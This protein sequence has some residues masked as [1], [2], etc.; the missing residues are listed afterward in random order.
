[1]WVTKQ[2]CCRDGYKD[3]S[4]QRRQPSPCRGT[5]RVNGADRTAGAP[6]PMLWF[7][8]TVFSAVKRT[9]A[10][11]LHRE[12]PPVPTD[13][14]GRFLPRPDVPTWGRFPIPAHPPYAPSSSPSSLPQSD[15]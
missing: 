5:Y 1:P 15:G 12:Y 2:T 7:R 3:R 4:G 11:P 14:N 13:R 6:L 8:S 9:A 10:S